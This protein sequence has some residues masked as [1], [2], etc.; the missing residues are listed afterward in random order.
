MTLALL[1]DLDGTLLHTD[2]LHE[3]VFAELF[4]EHGRDFDDGFYLRNIHGRHNLDI[5]A[6]HFPQEVPQAMSDA[7][8]LA[9]R[10]RLGA[11]AEPMPGLLS[12]LDRAEAAGWPMAVVTNA[13]RDNAEAMLAAIGLAER[14]P[15]RIIGDEC[16]RGKPDPAPYSA[17]MERLCVAPADCIAFEDSP[18]GLRSAR[19]AGAY[20]VGIRSSLSD[21]AL[22]DAGAQI[23]IADFT[24]PILPELLSRRIPSQGA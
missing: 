17:A 22:R 10:T 1:F 19:A 4:A 21:S 2:P 6:E 20:A 18:S 16:D 14:L 7:K 9:F 13:P 12:L 11:S 23:T 24:D 5:F 15:L 8:E 3:A